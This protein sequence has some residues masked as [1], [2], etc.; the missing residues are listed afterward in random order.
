MNIAVWSG[1]KFGRRERISIE[2]LREL[3][4]NKKQ[5]FD[6][7]NAALKLFLACRI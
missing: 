4:Q 3:V 7:M 1:V 6:I 2:S 5:V